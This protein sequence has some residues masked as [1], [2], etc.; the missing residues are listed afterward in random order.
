MHRRPYIT[1]IISL[2]IILAG[3]ALGLLWKA[4]TSTY[5][6]K[7][8]ISGKTFYLEV[9]DEPHER[10]RGLGGREGIAPNQGMLFEGFTP[11][12]LGF[13][14]EDMRFDIDIIWINTEG[15][16]IH[17]EPKVSRHSH[18]T[19]Y[20]NPDGTNAAMVIELAS[21]TTAEIGLKTGDTVYIER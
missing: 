8:L 14:M 19:T 15:K 6:T 12:Q 2:V 4:S 16:V 1:V 10:G 11:G 3:L 18:P 17:I 9:A 7:T 13:W 20:R 21:G 5:S